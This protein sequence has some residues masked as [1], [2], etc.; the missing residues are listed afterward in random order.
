MS[1]ILKLTKA[2]KI[3]GN[4]VK[5]LHYDFENLTAKDKINAGRRMKE[6]GLPVTIEETDPDYHFYLF[7]EAAGKADPSITT[8][9]VLRISAKDSQKGAALARDFFY[10]DSEDSEESFKTE[11]SK[12][13]SQE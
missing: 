7:A 8:E 4:D 2:I 13:Q 12:E 10:L 5:E 6:V 11:N 9:D 1:K 3:N